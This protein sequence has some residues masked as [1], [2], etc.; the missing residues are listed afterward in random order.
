LALEGGGLPTPPPPFNAM[1]GDRGGVL[2]G[3]LEGVGRVLEGGLEGSLEDPGN[4]RMTA[5]SSS[6]TSAIRLRCRDTGPSVCTRIFLPT[7]S[8]FIAS[9][10]ALRLALAVLA[11]A[12]SAK[13]VGA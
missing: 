8:R 11:S 10:S 2:E 7:N 5:L 9:A 6:P 13:T 4:R 3:A 1:G 12:S